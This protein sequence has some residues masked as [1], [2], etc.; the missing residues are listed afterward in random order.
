[1]KPVYIVSESVYVEG[2]RPKVLMAFDCKE[3]AEKMAKI[4]HWI[5][6]EILLVEN[7][8]AQINFRNEMPPFPEP[9]DYQR[10]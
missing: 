1:M 8:K 7:N 9:P 6:E 2:E 3:D 5:V 10:K 4:N